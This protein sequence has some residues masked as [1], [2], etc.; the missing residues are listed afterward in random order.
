M[1][2]KWP[3]KTGPINLEQKKVVNEIVTGINDDR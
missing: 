1:T 3:K 2:K